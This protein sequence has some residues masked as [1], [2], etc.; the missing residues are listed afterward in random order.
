MANA[1]MSSA[2]AKNPSLYPSDYEKIGTHDTVLYMVSDN[3]T[4]QD[5]PLVSH[6]FLKTA[7]RLIEKADAF[8]VKC[9]SSGVAHSAQRWLEMAQESG[10]EPSASS[11]F[12]QALFSAYVQ[13]PIASAVDLYTC[14]MHVLG[15]PDVVIRQDVLTRISGSQQDY[16]NHAHFLFYMFCCYLLIECNESSFGSGH[17]FRP[18]AAWPRL[19]VTWEQCTGYADDDFYFN[20]FGRWRFL[21]ID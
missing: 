11:A 17:T 7:A 4:A 19:R 3:F 18:D 2:A 9:E 15:R 5:A 16:A 14:G 1:F 20:S 10:N 8:A 21:N 12:W 13:F 6:H